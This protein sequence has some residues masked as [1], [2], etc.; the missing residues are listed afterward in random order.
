LL[1]S[2][3]H[4]FAPLVFFNIRVGGVLLEARIGEI[5]GRPAENVIA[6]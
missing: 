6:T 2:I 1:A 3:F 5:A 4:F